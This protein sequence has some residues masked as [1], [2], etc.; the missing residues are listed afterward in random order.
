MPETLTASTDQAT[1]KTY[2]VLK[3][4]GPG[5]RITRRYTMP[6]QDPLDPPLYERRPSVIKN[7]DAKIV[8][9][10]QDLD[11]PTP[12]SHVATDLIAQNYFRQAGFPTLDEP[13]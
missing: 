11:A 9:E 1:I 6:G 12:W 5:L 8:Q 3:P 10:I 2:P 13:G 7:P 4:Q